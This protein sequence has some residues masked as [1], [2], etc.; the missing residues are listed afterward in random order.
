MEKDLLHLLQSEGLQIES[1]DDIVKLKAPLDRVYVEIILTH[2]QSEFEEPNTLEMLVRG[3]A[4]PSQRFNGEILTDLFDR[5]EN[6]VLR[7]S[8]ANTIFESKPL[9]IENWLKTTINRD[10]IG[11][12]KEMLLL[13][14]PRILEVEESREYLYKYFEEFPTHSANAI[15]EI[16]TNED[17]EFLANHKKGKEK[18][19]IKEIEKAEKKIRKKLK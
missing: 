8:I 5:T 7:W 1:L 4:T 16:G 6:E 13:A 9:K 18:W 2:L 12:S 14:L 11:I 3:L 17:I 15:A 19:V 10:D